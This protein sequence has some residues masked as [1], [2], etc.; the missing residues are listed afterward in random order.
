MDVAVLVAAV[1]VKSHV[2]KL[3]SSPFVRIGQLDHSQALKYSI[4]KALSASGILWS[5]GGDGSYKDV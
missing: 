5:K 4:D 1:I 3:D 2:Y